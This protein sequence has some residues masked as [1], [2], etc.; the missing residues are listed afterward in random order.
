VIGRVCGTR[1][2]VFAFASIP[3]PAT[4]TLCRPTIERIAV[5][6]GAFVVAEVQVVGAEIP[7]SGF[8]FDVGDSAFKPIGGAGCGFFGPTGGGWGAG[9]RGFGGVSGRGAARATIQS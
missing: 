4:V 7:H 8:G 9:I 2:D 1:S 6:T 3:T 5:G